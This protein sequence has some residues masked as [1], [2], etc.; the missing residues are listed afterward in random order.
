MTSPVGVRDAEYI[1]LFRGFVD[2]E[3]DPLEFRKR[4]F[5]TYQSDA[6]LGDEERYE[7][8]QR[9]FFGCEDLEVDDD[10]RD[11]DEID[12][13]ELR[14]IVG[15]AANDLRHRHDDWEGRHVEG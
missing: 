5:A 12:V 7:V 14:A 15:Q 3:S 11:D 10:L 2:A 4:F 13:D 9:V 6:R 8:L 1:E